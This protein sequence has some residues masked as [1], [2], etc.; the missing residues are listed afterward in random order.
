MPE[1]QLWRAG[2]FLM[3]VRPG[4]T[5]LLCIA[6]Q[7][8]ASSACRRWGAASGT[9]WTGAPSSWWTSASAS[10]ATS[11]CCRAGACPDVPRDRLCNAVAVAVVATALR[12]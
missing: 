2:C 6:A 12:D 11:A 1:A 5:P 7:P 8:P 10:P 4:T 9:A 3:Q